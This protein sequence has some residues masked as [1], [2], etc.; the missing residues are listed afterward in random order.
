MEAVGYQKELDPTY[1]APAY[2]PPHP[3]TARPPTR[4]VTWRVTGWPAPRGLVLGYPD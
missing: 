3:L 1:G 4:D 2:P